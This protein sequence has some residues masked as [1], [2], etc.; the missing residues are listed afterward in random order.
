[1]QDPSAWHVDAEKN[2]SK[3]LD[4]PYRYFL[5]F[6]PIFTPKITGQGQSPLIGL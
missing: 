5:I 4:L 1:M 3:V 6:F 2:T